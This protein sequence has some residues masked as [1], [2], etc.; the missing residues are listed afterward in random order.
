MTNNN[1]GV[2]GYGNFGRA[3]SSDIFHARSELEIDENQDRIVGI[4]RAVKKFI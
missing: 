4:N 3:W 2:V 1:F